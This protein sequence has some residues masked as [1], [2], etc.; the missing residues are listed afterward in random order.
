MK[1][2]TLQPLNK[3]GKA[4]RLASKPRADG[5]LICTEYS[6]PGFSSI[7]TVKKV[8]QQLRLEAGLNWMKV[9]QA[10]TDLKQCCLLNA[11]ALC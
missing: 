9:S 11:Q 5:P 3:M 7:T 8:V 10:A 2:S 1:Q 4:Q 6:M